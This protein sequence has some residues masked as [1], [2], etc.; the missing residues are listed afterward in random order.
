MINKEGNVSTVFIRFMLASGK[1]LL[2]L[3]R[4]GETAALAITV[5]IEIDNMAT[6]NDLFT[7]YYVFTKKM[8]KDMDYHPDKKV[9]PF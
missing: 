4:A 1:A 3:A 6:V 5:I 7:V 9:Y 8:R 2:M